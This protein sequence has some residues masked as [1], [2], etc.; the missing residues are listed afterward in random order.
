MSALYTPLTSSTQRSPGK[1]L[2]IALEYLEN[3]A[4]G[5]GYCSRISGVIGRRVQGRELASA[6]TLFM[7]YSSHGKLK[8]ILNLVH[9][10]I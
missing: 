5:C 10:Y 4:G 3:P 8:S 9:A 7:V 2:P 1:K 6:W